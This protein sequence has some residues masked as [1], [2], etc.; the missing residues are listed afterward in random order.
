M[1]SHLSS[2][3]LTAGA[4][5]LPVTVLAMTGH[6]PGLPD[7][8]SH[9][10]H[11]PRVLA[12]QAALAT[13]VVFG[14]GW[15]LLVKGARS[16]FRRLNMFTLI[17]LGV[18][19]TYLYSLAAW[20]APHLFP[21]SFQGEH[22]VPVFFEAAAMI[23][24]LVLAG[25][26]MESRAQQRT[27]SAIR[28]L[29]ALTPQSAVRIEPAGERTVP[30]DQIAVGD[31]LRVRPGGVIPVDGTI[32]EGEAYLDESTMTGEP[33]PRHA[34]VGDPVRAGTINTSGSL[35]LIAEQVG[36]HTVLARIIERIREAQETQAPIQRIADQV[37]GWVVPAVLVIAAITFAIWYR[38]GPE[39]R[40][41]FALINAVTVLMITCPCAL[42]LATPMSIVV[43]MGRG[44]RQGIMIRNAETIE[45]LC[46]IDT[47]VLDKTG[48]LTQGRPEVV[49]LHARTPESESA[50]LQI[51]ASLETHSE[52]P[53][54]RAIVN[55]ADAMQL[56]RLPVSGF[57]A[58]PGL[59]VEGEVEGQYAR[60]G[61][62]EWLRSHH[63]SDMAVW[64]SAAEPAA[65]EG[66]IV[67]F[68]AHGQECLGYL[69][70]A[71]PLRETSAPAVAAMQAMGLACI[72]LT[73]DSE[74]TARHL[75][76]SVGITRV[77]AGVLPG[78][79]Q[80]LIKQLQQEGR[81]VAMIG[82]GMNDAPA[83][84][85]AHVGIAMGSGT[86][87]ALESADVALLDGD[88]NRAVAAFR[89]GSLVM[90]NIRQ[91]LVFAFIYNLISIP[92]AAGVLFP[93][94]GFLL[95]PMVAS[96]AMSLSSFS[97]V[98][99]ALRLRGADLNPAFSRVNSY[100][101]LT[102]P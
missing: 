8:I 29:M 31:H 47:V 85:T 100:P 21:P 101:P 49:G 37:T 73:G 19:V 18:M 6:V 35:V 80:D 90:R 42:G 50:L 10:L 78:D 102:K 65:R 14:C 62:A 41:L 20:L 99:N 81:T 5:T 59:G 53:L 60:I 72:M 86:D 88:L 70:I 96:I 64:T 13:V 89:L 95:T 9:S 91:N 54:A 15:P 76:E 44:A 46:H 56:S 97:V 40:L 66:K 82:D 77:H 87:I 69:V 57:H 16:W 52:H 43:G 23:T 36:G 63:V 74:T 33:I 32:I 67:S 1:I 7:S 45:Q 55:K 68:I 79:K 38:I 93:W 2:R 98:T 71:D 27:G 48:T 34:R 22:G 28:S 12:L 11:D 30:L 26:W 17:S 92:I 61:K 94:T 51:A 58:H 25:Q 75:A 24:T 83:L 39:P 3:T 84:A 4:M